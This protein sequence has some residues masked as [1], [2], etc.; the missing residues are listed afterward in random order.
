MT[1]KDTDNK[2]EQMFGYGIIHLWLM[3]F[4]ALFIGTVM[5]C[6]FFLLV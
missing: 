2:T 6:D 3:C 1:I 4:I 5:E